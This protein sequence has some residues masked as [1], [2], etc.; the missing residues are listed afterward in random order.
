MNKMQE[1]FLRVSLKPVVE[2]ELPGRLRIG[3]ARFNLLPDDAKPYLHYVYD[4]LEML[5]GVTD[6][7][8][9]ERIGTILILYDSG[10]C[11]SR[12]VLQW[13]DTV[14][15]TG[16]ELARE[17]DWQPSD[18]KLLEKIMRDRLSARLPR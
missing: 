11:T 16:I 15:D 3:F 4:V 17:R 10:K 5:P 18:E 6:V 12:R 7:R 8:V 1:H 2:S 14:V 9:N 13:V